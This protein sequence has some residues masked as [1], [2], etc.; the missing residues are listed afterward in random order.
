MQIPFVST[1]VG[2]V[3]PA[4]TNQ[5]QPLP[6]DKMVLDTA[7]VLYSQPYVDQASRP[8]P[9]VPLAHC[10]TPTGGI[11][12]GCEGGQLFLV[13]S[14]TGSA[15]VL[16]SPLAAAAVEE[17]EGA[18]LVTGV[19]DL[20]GGDGSVARSGGVG[21]EVSGMAR[22]EE[23]GSGVDLGPTG[24]PASSVLRAGDIGCLALNR[25]GLY[26]AGKVCRKL[27]CYRQLQDSSIRTLVHSERACI[28]LQSWW[29]MEYQM[30]TVVFCV[31]TKCA[32]LPTSEWCPVLL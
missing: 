17:G 19:A 32:I 4:R 6:V 20:L 18:G 26:A 15:T 9:V 3:L 14:E 5:L 2:K 7:R 23:E 12:C 29:C 11:Y 1:P 28:A 30:I 22:V 13:D 31:C 8:Q 27:C 16:V 10:W 24:Q 25:R 21:G